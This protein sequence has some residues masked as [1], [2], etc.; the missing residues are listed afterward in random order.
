A[1]QRRWRS[2][3][4]VLPHPLPLSPRAYRVNEV[5]IVVFCTDLP[6]QVF[7]HTGTR[8]AATPPDLGGFGAYQCARTLAV[9]GSWLDGRGRLVPVHGGCPAPTARLDRA[10]DCG[11]GLAR[12]WTDTGADRGGLLLLSGLPG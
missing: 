12:L 11:A 4:G 1:R 10:S 7:D 9:A 2:W 5:S 3:R 6:C 8:P